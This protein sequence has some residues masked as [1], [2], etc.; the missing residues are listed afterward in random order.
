MFDT[1]HEICLVLFIKFIIILQNYINYLIK[2]YVFVFF[3]LFLE[4]LC[5]VHCALCIFFVSLQVKLG[6]ICFLEI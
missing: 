3:Y 4:I 5:I 2:A 6:E 1:R